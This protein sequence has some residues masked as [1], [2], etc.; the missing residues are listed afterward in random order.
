MFED[1]YTYSVLQSGF[2]PED[3]VPHSI[4]ERL[5]FLF[6]ILKCLRGVEVLSVFLKCLR[7]VEEFSHK[8]KQ[9]LT[10]QLVQLSKERSLS[11]STVSTIER[12]G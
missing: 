10:G 6:F 8:M 11:G 9:R 2:A 5:S 3:V 1:S 4:K 7:G 12:K